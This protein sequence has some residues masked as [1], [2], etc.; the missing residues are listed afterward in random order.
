MYDLFCAKSVSHFLKSIFF[1]GEKK[2]SFEWLNNIRHWAGKLD[3]PQR[4]NYI[5]GNL[6]LKDSSEISLNSSE[7]S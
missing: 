1:E 7:F 4:N 3:L 6:Q 5:H 2:M